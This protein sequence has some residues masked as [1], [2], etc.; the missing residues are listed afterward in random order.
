M[1]RLKGRVPG[2][3]T[4]QL[5]LYLWHGVLT[6]HTSGIAGAMAF[7]LTQA[8]KLV[9][10]SIGTKPGHEAY[11][12]IMNTQPTLHRIPTGFHVWGGG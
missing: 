8:R 4:R 7:T 10:D 9:I 11:K 5:K 1:P 6:D 12:E 3:G 2:S